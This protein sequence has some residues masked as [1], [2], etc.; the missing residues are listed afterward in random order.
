MDKKGDYGVV[1]PNIIFHVDSFEEVFSSLHLSNPQ[2][3]VAIQL[4][5]VNKVK[6]ASFDKGSTGYW[7]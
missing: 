7:G 3:K 4:L 1:Y 2:Q 5:A 6:L